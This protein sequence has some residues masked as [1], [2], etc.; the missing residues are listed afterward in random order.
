METVIERMLDLVQNYEKTLLYSSLEYI[1][2]G[3]KIITC[4][5]PKYEWLSKEILF[6]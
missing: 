5:P 1:Y 2:S 4:T 3:A 6:P